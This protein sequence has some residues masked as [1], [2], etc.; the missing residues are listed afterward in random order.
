MLPYIRT[1]LQTRL[2][3]HFDNNSCE[4]VVSWLI[5]AQDRRAVIVVGAGFSKNAVWK[6]PKTGSA[7]DE[8]PIWSEVDQL[9]KDD[10]GL[11]P[12]ASYGLMLPDLY[13]TQI[14]KPKYH[15]VL[16][17]RLPDDEIMPGPV[18]QAL[19]D[20]YRPEA[21]ITTNQLDTLLD[22]GVTEGE[23]DRRWFRVQ[24][25]TALAQP[26]A[27]SRVQLIYLHGHRSNPR[28]WV[29]GLSQYEDLDRNTPVMMRRVRQLLSQHPI[30]F[31]GF[32][33]TD[34]NFH[35]LV[36]QI[37]REMSQGQPKNL[38][39]MVDSQPPA[40]VKHWQSYGVQIA[41]FK[42]TDHIEE[43]FARLFR[44]MSGVGRDRRPG[45]GVLEFDELKSMLLELASFR[46]R[47]RLLGTMLKSRQL[48][49][50][51]LKARN[52]KEARRLW[53]KLWQEIA[54]PETDE[55][56]RR[57]HEGRRF[58][59]RSELPAGEW[60]SLGEARR[61]EI[62]EEEKYSFL[63]VLPEDRF[64]DR[65]REV[66][67]VASLLTRGIGIA[68]VVAWLQ[69]WFD[70]MLD[71]GF[72]PE[73]SSYNDEEIV[74]FCNL[75]SFSSVRLF[76]AD[77]GEKKNC[78]SLMQRC[79]EIARRYQDTG[80]HYFQ[81]DW[82]EVV[83]GVEAKPLAL[84]TMMKE[85]RN[86]VFE[87]LFEDAVGAYLKVRGSART[88]NRPWYEWLA[89]EGALNTIHR[90]K[91]SD[92]AKAEK[93]ESQLSGWEQRYEK[94][95]KLP[96]ISSWNDRLEERKNDLLAEALKENTLAERKRS[97]LN[98]TQTSSIVAHEAWMSWRDLQENGA[99]PWQTMNLLSWALPAGLFSSEEEFGL[100][101][102][103]CVK[104]TDR[105]LKDLAFQSFPADGDKRTERDLMI[106]EALF[107]SKNK[108][109]T[110]KVAALKCIGGLRYSVQRDQISF[111]AELLTSL[112][113]DLGTQGCHVYNAKCSTLADDY[114][115]AWTVYASLLKTEE[116]LKPLD[117]YIRSIDDRGEMDE[118]LGGIARYPWSR[119]SKQMGNAKV[120]KLAFRWRD[121][122]R[123]I[124]T[125]RCAD[126]LVCVAAERCHGLEDDPD[127]G[128]D[129]ADEILKSAMLAAQYTG[130]YND[131]TKNVAVVATGDFAVHKKAFKEVVE[132]AYPNI[133]SAEELKGRPLRNRIEVL[134][135]LLPVYQERKDCAAE[136]KAIFE[137]LVS[138]F[139][140]LETPSI[141]HI[142]RNPHQR[143]TTIT[144]QAVSEYCSHKDL[145]VPSSERFLQLMKAEPAAVS[146]LASVLSEDFWPDRWMKVK[147]V[148][149]QFA[150]PSIH[151]DSQHHQA[152]VVVM[153][154]RLLKFK[155][156][157]TAGWLVPIWTH[158][159]VSNTG[160]QSMLANH[161]TSLTYAFL[162]SGL[163][164]EESELWRIAAESALAAA[165]DPRV[166]VRMGVANL[167]RDLPNGE[168]AMKTLRD[169]LKQQ[170][171]KETY[172][173]ARSD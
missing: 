54:L 49:G 95:S 132:A 116:Q 123:T 169:R 150:R 72:E 53:L 164:E 48:P 6:E 96:D 161:Q 13:T 111:L 28:S 36:R 8:I 170:Y 43:G 56:R 57:V 104:D 117:D 74:G 114:A 44:E 67:L 25:D 50:G 172:A 97:Q 154:H 160:E 38:A 125:W 83:P 85:A 151:S 159:L 41:T 173:I 30:L 51:G 103:Y 100:R 18:H 93:H 130:R 110:R 11:Q 156:L 59:S 148:V 143:F 61:S 47:V 124:Q 133:L 80:L 24:D 118:V 162:K 29:F 46:A 19:F 15:D 1:A 78:T 131:H 33:L 63:G 81:T 86:L 23:I 157:A 147:S 141:E 79:S 165:S 70:E 92:T 112:R 153:L 121:H 122:A 138:L 73:Q 168:A 120:M 99:A 163:F 10:L 145:P 127:V 4:E 91:V 129:V 9:L 102:Q 158:G 12:E 76:E 87:G 37:D 52:I 152:N 55:D 82:K 62:I 105:W 77:D 107:A 108:S 17:K 22:R 26:D 64:H 34:P 90:L 71:V 136:A 84:V 7:S 58:L 5:A 14:G 3:V 65:V 68:D 21:V 20:L 69:V 137:R 106:T 66:R 98:Q 144:L 171:E 2:Q 135:I 60:N 109:L 115:N 128:D 113:S 155:E 40:F 142:K 45:E 134:A 119:W 146:S 126:V 88:E 32:S 167:H 75:L 89:L 140:E 16:L 139:S 94:L 149:L 39:I 35:A 101:L 166:V 27:E 31:V 42:G